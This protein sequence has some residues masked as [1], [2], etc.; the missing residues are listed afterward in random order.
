METNTKP[1]I[2]LSSG[3]VVTHTRE[4]GGNWLA[5]MADGGPMSEAEWSDYCL[6]V[7]LASVEAI[8]AAKR[9]RHKASKAAFAK[10]IRNAK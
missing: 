9:A 7:Q 2:T 1:D 3:R 6:R 5:T 4:A 10:A 8:D